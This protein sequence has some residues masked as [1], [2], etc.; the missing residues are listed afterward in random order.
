MQ[1]ENAILVKSTDEYWTY[2][3]WNDVT[4]KWNDF[5]TQFVE[6]FIEWEIIKFEKTARKKI[7]QFRQNRV[8][9]K[10]LDRKNVTCEQLGELLPNLENN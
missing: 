3:A 2:L 5:D 8:S 9:I 6:I 10:C 7:S 1:G 4:W